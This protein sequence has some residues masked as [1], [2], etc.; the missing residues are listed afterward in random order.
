MALA[1]K[2][3]LTLD[4][5]IYVKLVNISVRKYGSARHISRV[6]NELLAEA[7]K[8]EELNPLEELKELLSEPKLAKVTPKEFE[9][10]REKLS[11]RFE[12]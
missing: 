9:K 8:K 6:V 4:D 1:R 3:T 10:F 12:S 7:L 2:T 5:E 11:R